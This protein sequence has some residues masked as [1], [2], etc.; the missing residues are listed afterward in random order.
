M[1]IQKPVVTR[2]APSPTGTLHVG[3]ARSALFNYLYAKKHNGTFIVRIEDTDK[4]R[5]T[6][7]FEND[8]LSGLQKLGLKEDKVYRQSERSD[9]YI[10]YIQTLIDSGAAYVS[11]E[12]SKATPG[13]E[14]EVVRLKNPNKT[15]TFVDEIRG[16]IS[17]DTTDLGDFVIARSQTDPLYHLAVV[18]DDHDMGVTH[19]IRG[20]D[21]ISNTPRQILIQE[22]LQ[23]DRPIYAHMPLI[24]AADK[25]KLS[26]R[27]GAVSVNAYME[28]YET[29][30]LVNYLA[31]L[32]WNPGTEQEF[33]TLEELIHEFDIHKIQK[34]GAIFSTEKL[35]SINHHYLKA[36]PFDVYVNHVTNVV[37]D[38]IL[39][40]DLYNDKRLTM[41]AKELQ[42]RAKNMAEMT[43]L[44]DH[45]MDF[46]FFP[47]KLDIKKIIWKDSTHEETKVHLST[48]HT[49][50][51][52]ISE[53]SF[54]AQNI[55]NALWGYAEEN[56]R[57]AVLWPLRY[58]LTGKDKSPD[59]FSVAETLQ[60]DEALLRIQNAIDLL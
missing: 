16:E 3:T 12:E 36:L 53:D 28:N 14:V 49:T 23:I 13:E 48:T 45:E 1:D 35:D 54:T 6:K 11:K 17:F 19:I 56:G 30:A 26:K 59:P 57:G 40:A 38:R 39:K 27:H 43:N 29:P 21:H 31:L 60:K 9:V 15:V 24:L 44:L 58:A 34:G 55:K 32:G 2:I 46:Y 37:P 51:A 41:V 52:E 47:V 22:A 33:F 25:S 7:E 4:E 42:E 20:E 5:S 10:P 18:I 50:I 8:I